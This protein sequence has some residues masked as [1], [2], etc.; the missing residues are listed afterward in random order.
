MRQVQ[1]TEYRQADPA[2]TPVSIAAL[3]LR[4]SY[5]QVRRLLSLGNL[6]GGFDPEVGY[7]VDLRDRPE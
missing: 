5:N 1:T 2:K 4:L 3:R 7:Y 6:P